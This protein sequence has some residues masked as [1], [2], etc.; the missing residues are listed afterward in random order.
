[1]SART[2]EL[3]FFRKP[4]ERQEG[5]PAQPPPTEVFKAEILRSLNDSRRVVEPRLSI[6]G[7]PWRLTT[8]CLGNS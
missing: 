5:F 6:G 2:P 8:G 3:E 7:L 1:M 4:S